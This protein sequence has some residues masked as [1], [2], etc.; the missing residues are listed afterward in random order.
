MLQVGG[1][2]WGDRWLVNLRMHSYKLVLRRTARNL[3]N[4]EATFCIEAFVRF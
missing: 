4:E 1:S 3:L 2:E